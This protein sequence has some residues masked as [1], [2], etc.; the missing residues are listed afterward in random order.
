MALPSPYRKGNEARHEENAKMSFKEIR[1]GNIGVGV[2]GG[3]VDI[4]RPE[5]VRGPNGMAIPH[6]SERLNYLSLS[7]Q[8]ARR[9]AQALLTAVAVCDASMSDEGSTK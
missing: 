1:I 7:P 3:L 5:I 4:S 6:R 9:L 8:N 2:A